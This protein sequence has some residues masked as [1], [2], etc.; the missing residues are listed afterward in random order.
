MIAF[1]AVAMPLGALVVAVNVYLPPHL[2]GHLGVSM[3]VVGGAWATVRLLDLLVDPILGLIM[4]RTRTRLGRYRFWFLIGAPALMAAL[5]ALFEA[6][7]GVGSVYLVAWLLALYFGQSVLT[8][9]Q[10]AWAASL[11]PDYNGRSRLFGA[12][13]LATVFGG[14]AVLM[15]PVMGSRQGW[16]IGQSAQAM[17]WF[18]VALTPLAVLLAIILTPEKL[19]AERHPSLAPRLILSLLTKPDLVR[20]FFAQM[21]LT[22]GPGWMSALYLFYVTSAR[23]YSS[24][25]ASLLLLCYILAG[26]VG[27]LVIARLA[28]AVGKHRALMAVAVL[29][30][31]DICL[32]SVVPKGAMAIAAPLFG[33]AGFAAAGFD[34]TI[35][36]MLADVGD[37]V[38]LEQGQDQLSLIYALNTLANKIASA[39][40]IGLT[41]PLLSL[42][43]F[44]PK[45]GAVN[46]PSAIRGLELAYVVG[47]VVFVLIGALCLIGWR[48]DGKRHAQIRLDLDARDA[49]AVG[50]VPEAL[51]GAGAPV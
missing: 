49:L 44:D 40:A 4:D 29:F 11:A 10:S 24:E 1:S 34:L 9:G 26:I 7:S 3:T 43:G 27:A 47:P 5:Y 12:I 14:V 22:L 13:S 30:A 16:G 46:T 2:A 48:L 23:G 20:L 33:I 15:I 21:T 6:P 37:E 50:R 36:A 17:G 28:V 41:F 8:M 32:T 31:A 38:R 45:E 35:R 42:L 51:T 25:Q 18:M 39:F 19:R